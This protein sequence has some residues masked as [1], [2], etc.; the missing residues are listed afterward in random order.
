MLS[1]NYGRQ[2]LDVNLL[3]ESIYHGAK[4][5]FGSMITAHPDATLT[6]FGLFSDD[7]A[8]TIVPAAS[9]SEAIAEADEDGEAIWNTSAWPFDDG[10]EF[11]DPAYRMI[12][13]PHQGIPC[14]ADDDFGRSVFESCAEALKRLR[15]EGFFGEPS[16]ELVVLF[17]VSDSNAAIGL[18]E[19]LNTQSTFK[20]YSDWMAG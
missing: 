1:G 19:S 9:S 14:D 8:M 13:P 3:T 15:D 7:S 16:D 5:A 20:R 4:L 12:L 10:G 2:G 11:L 17:Q 6:Q 18:N